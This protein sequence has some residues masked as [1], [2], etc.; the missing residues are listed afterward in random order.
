MVSRNLQNEGYNWTDDDVI[1]PLQPT[2]NSDEYK[3]VVKKSVTYIVAAVLFNERGEVL[4]MQVGEW[5]QLCT[6]I[7]ILVAI[8]RGMKRST[9]GGTKQAEKMTMKNSNAYFLQ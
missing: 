1:V 3:P 8:L 5:C 4:M 6:W 9:I 2:V 7:Q